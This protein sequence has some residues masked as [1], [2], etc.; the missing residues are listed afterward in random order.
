MVQFP[1]RK[2][3]LILQ[4]VHLLAG[5]VVYSRIA[6]SSHFTWVSSSSGEL[7][8]TWHGDTGFSKKF[9]WMHVNVSNAAWSEEIT[10]GQTKATQLRTSVRSNVD[11]S[12]KEIASKTCV[13]HPTQCSLQQILF[14]DLE[15]VMSL[16]SFQAN[17]SESYQPKHK[18][19]K[20]ISTTTSQILN[21]NH[22]QRTPI[23]THQK[24]S[25]IF[26]LPSTSTAGRQRCFNWRD[27]KCAAKSKPLVPTFHEVI[28]WTKL[29]L[30]SLCGW[31]SIFFTTLAGWFGLG[32]AGF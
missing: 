10:V 31:R 2:S 32:G 30:G 15:Q 3:K 29:F 14:L 13:S 9:R 4:G 1:E 5:L 20:Y 6:W 23:L 17:Q 19:T 7:A 12:W 18:P 21:C 28:C 27:R 11:Q 8:I 22:T 25:Q 16:S 24:A 26:P